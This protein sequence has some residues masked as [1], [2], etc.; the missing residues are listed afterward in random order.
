MAALSGIALAA[1][2]L[3]IAIGSGNSGQPFL[4]RMSPFEVIRHLLSGP[5]GVEDPHHF[6]VWQ[7]RLPRAL[8]CLLVGGLLGSVGSAFQALFRNPL[9]EPYI[10]GV[11]SGSAAGGALALVL[12]LGGWASGLGVMAFAFLGG[13]GSLA[14]VLAL[15]GRRGRTDVQTLLLAGVVIGAM[16]AS[17]LSLI[18]YAAGMDSN[19]IL[20]WM[21]GSTTPMHWNRVAVLAGVL[22]IGLT[23]LIPQGKRLNALAVSDETA[24]RLGVDIRKLKATVLAIGTGMTAAAVGSVGIIGF[25]GLVAPHIARRVLGVD[26]RLSMAGAGA[27]GATLLLFADVLA[28]RL[29]PGGEIPVGVVTAILGAPFLLALMRRQEG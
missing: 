13:A 1:L 2:V 24:Q 25:L 3:H 28:Q 7:L 21:L 20:R 17:V 14:L 18:L 10:V 29:L 11:S 22:L 19:Q 9:A 6:I 23:V 27:V 4:F 12:G 8:A 26:W 5:G 16:L 15:A